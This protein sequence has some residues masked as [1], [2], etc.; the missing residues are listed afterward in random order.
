MITLITD[1]SN[2][3]HFNH[4]LLFIYI[5]K[6]LNSI[7]KLDYNKKGNQIQIIGHFLL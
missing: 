3:I 2:E 4:I 7:G 1:K 5:F 6:D